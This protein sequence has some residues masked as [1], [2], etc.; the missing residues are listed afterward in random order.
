VSGTPAS[1]TLTLT[2]AGTCTVTA[3]QP[4]DAN[5]AAAPDVVRML[6]ISKAATSLKQRP[7]SLV[8]SVLNFRITYT[9]T[10][11]S[12]VTGQPIAG[13]TIAFSA[14]NSAT[15]PAACT[16]ITN[17]AGTA[18]CTSPILKIVVIL[19]TG[20]TTARYSGSANY[21]PSTNTTPFRLL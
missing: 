19:L 11:T 5:V 12:Q 13:Q 18:T 7:V 15:G 17:S 6:T 14:S 16:A 8:G 1:P 21:E 9:A 4:G 10:L 3:G 20:T 2:G